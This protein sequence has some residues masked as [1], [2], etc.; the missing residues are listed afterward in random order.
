MTAP[1]SVITR[2]P[3]VARPRIRPFSWRR[4]PVGL[5]IL[6]GALLPATHLAPELADIQRSGY[7]NVDDFDNVYWTYHLSPGQMIGYIVDPEFSFFRPVGM[8]P[9]WLL[10]RAFNLDPV[11]F[12]AFQTGVNLLN[13]AL[14]CALVLSVSHSH[15][16]AVMATFLWLTAVALL[17]ALWWFASIHYMFATT[18]FVLGLLAF[19]HVRHWLTKTIAVAVAYLL[20]IKSQET[21]V[22]LPA[23]LLA[24]ELI[25][26]RRVVGGVKARASLYATLLFIGGA[27]TLIKYHAMSASDQTA[28]YAFN[29]SLG[30][31]I[32]NATWY[33]AQL[34]PWLAP[35]N[36]PVALQALVGLGLLAL[37]L[38]DRVMMFGLA[39]TAITA[40]PVI[41]L[42]EH[43]FAFYWYLSAIG[44]WTSVA[45][46]AQ[47]GTA[48]IRRRSRLSRRWSAALPVAVL[49]VTAALVEVQDG[50]YRTPRVEW[51]RA[52]AAMF[53]DFV[54][55]VVA[56][57]DPPAAAVIQVADAPAAFDNQ[58]L[59]TVY[60]VVYDRNDIVVTRER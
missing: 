34:L 43:H 2:T 41:F 46:L 19:L 8:F 26:R 3:A 57:P 48:L 52:R 32:S 9:Y 31:L 5:T 12:H 53:R 58:A 42:V 16:T 47:R 55:S 38:S 27:F 25:A 11:V 23:V 15:L 33:S 56:Q 6:L 36:Q 40:L 37:V 28:G 21:A 4:L 54:E 60:R 49:F 7:F 20:A 18:W 24:Y 35:D 1:A 30:Q 29:F 51:T 10:G 44:I 50:E 39:F 14:V 45:R 22:T 59:T 17:D 13:A